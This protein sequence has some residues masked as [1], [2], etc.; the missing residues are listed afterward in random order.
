MGG[1]GVGGGG[2]G[3]GGGGGPPPPPPPPPP[4]VGVGVRNVWLCCTVRIMSF[5]RL[6][7]RSIARI[8]W[9]LLPPLPIWDLGPACASHGKSRDALL[10]RL[11]I[12]NMTGGQQK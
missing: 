7:C 11:R 12:R 10:P 8:S 4:G 3:G 5:T 6:T 2:W 1:G 9:L